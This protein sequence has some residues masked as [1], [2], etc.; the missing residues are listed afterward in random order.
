M[1]QFFRYFKSNKFSFVDRKHDL[2]M[3]TGADLDVEITKESS[4]RLNVSLSP[5]ALTMPSSNASLDLNELRVGSLIEQRRSEYSIFQGSLGSKPYLIK[6]F[7]K[8]QNHFN[9]REVYELISSRRQRESVRNFLEYFGS[10]ESLKS[11]DGSTLKN[12]VVLESYN[13]CYLSDVLERTSISWLELCKMLS[14][15]SQG[16]SYLHGFN[17]TTEPNMCHR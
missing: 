7:P 2:E 4:P 1:I 14:T 12:F 9:E 3:P 15:I 5:E 16:L 6:S 10:G 17:R 13:D 8:K 11:N